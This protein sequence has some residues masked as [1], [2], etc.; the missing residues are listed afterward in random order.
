[1]RGEVSEESV[2]MWQKELAQKSS[3][4]KAPMLQP[5]YLSIDSPGGDIVAGQAFIEFAKTIP[6]L[7]TITLFG[8]SMASGI[9]QALPGKRYVLG[10]SITMFHRA[11]GG[12]QGQFSE[13]EVESR[14]N[15]AKDL[16]AILENANAS[17]MKLPIEK[18]K[19]LVKD[20]YWVVGHKN[21]TENVADESVSITCS[22]ELIENSKSQTF[23]V[24]I[25][26]ITV[27]FSEC[28]LFRSGEVVKGQDA[29]I[30]Y[31]SHFNKKLTGVY[32]MSGSNYAAKN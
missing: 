25:F 19:Q 22:D 30:K 3:A 2:S 9:Q 6:N 4:R 17:R 15:M 31:K 11:S 21:I 1:M 14:L 29:Y 7:H 10:T 32:Y 5:L 20:E 13:G 24:F 16:V 8:A 27:K 26:T 28:P 12:F 23:Q 18:Y